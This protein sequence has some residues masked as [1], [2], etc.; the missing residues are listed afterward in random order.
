MI[1]NTIHIYGRDVMLVDCDEYTKQWFKENL[2]I[3]QNAL[4]TWQP[5][6]NLI[7]HRIPEHNGI[8]NEEDTF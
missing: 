6:K 4:P 8:G 2:W 5:P 1:G 7:H 3:D